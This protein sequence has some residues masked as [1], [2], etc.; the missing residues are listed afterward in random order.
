METRTCLLPQFEATEAQSGDMTWSSSVA[1]PEP[2]NSESNCYKA[3]QRLSRTWTC[4]SDLGFCALNMQRRWLNQAAQP[5]RNKWLWLRSSRKLKS[6]TLWLRAYMNMTVA[7]LHPEDSWSRWPARHTPPYS[8][9]SYK[10]YTSWAPWWPDSIVSP[11]HSQD[12]SLSGWWEDTAAVWTV[13]APLGEKP[14]EEFLLCLF[15]SEGRQMSRRPALLQI[16]RQ[17][18]VLWKEG[19]LFRGFIL[20]PPP[21]TP[22]SS[23]SVSG[24]SQL[25]GFT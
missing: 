14:G 8:Y 23:L 22:G 3:W 19:W 11:W 20:S 10:F 5:W 21:L 9:N 7:S 1:T 2:K 16:S 13:L 18:L 15:R 24:D 12:L 25:Q 6:I 17:Q 4:L